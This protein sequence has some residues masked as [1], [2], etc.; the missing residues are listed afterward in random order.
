MIVHPIKAILFVQQLC[1]KVNVIALDT[2]AT[3][4]AINWAN[5]VNAIALL[6]HL[7]VMRS[8]LTQL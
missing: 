7:Q 4:K 8:L 6:L 5:K 1:S 3:M 2:T